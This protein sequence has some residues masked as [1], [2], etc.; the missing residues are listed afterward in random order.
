MVEVRVLCC[1][2]GVR[3]PRVY[4][5]PWLLAVGRTR[6]GVR[7]PST[8]GSYRTPG[9]PVTRGNARR[10]GVLD[11]AAFVAH[12]DGAAPEGERRLGRGV[13]G[14]IVMRG[15]GSPGARV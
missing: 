12:P 6:R 9:A 13:L 2:A 10:S 14:S 4:W 11:Q 1:Q 8:L 15:G 3:H 5:R 7:R